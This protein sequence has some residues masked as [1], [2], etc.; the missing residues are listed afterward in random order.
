MN[1]KSDIIRLSTIVISY[2][3][4]MAII[5]FLSYTTESQLHQE[6]MKI[7]YNSQDIKRIF[8]T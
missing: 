5:S 4:H 7:I 3:R 8:Q 6:T 2:F 1:I